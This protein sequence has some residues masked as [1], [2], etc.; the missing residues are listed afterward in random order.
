[1]PEY[2]QAGKFKAN[3]LKVMDEVS[4]SRRRIIITKHNRPVVQIVPIDSKPRSLF[5][6]LKGTIHSYGDLIFP[7]DETWNADS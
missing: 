4:H 2:L 5:G 6:C 7:I 3:C 1:M